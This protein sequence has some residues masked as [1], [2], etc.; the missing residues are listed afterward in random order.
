MSN[1]NRDLVA[2]VLA[3]ELAEDS[4]EFREAVLADPMLQIE[5]DE[6]RA[7]TAMM[8]G[9]AAAEREARTMPMLE[10][11][12]KPA[13]SGPKFGG[14]FAGVAAAAALLIA[15]FAMQGLFGG[16]DP[17]ANTGN[18]QTLS[19]GDLD[20]TQVSPMGPDASYGTFTATGAIPSIASIEL[21]I[22]EDSEDADEPIILP[23]PITAEE[24]TPEGFAWSPSPEILGGL[25]ARIRWQIR[26]IGFGGNSIG[27]S[28]MF[29]ASR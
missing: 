5:L 4:P 3:G 20:F 19:A 22:W 2:D 16:N 11:V 8:D 27:D 9:E 28:T 17:T 6:M 25:P 13:S 18:L 12:E 10:L 15:I 7:L 26:L 1:Q 23:H 29:F 24:L 21:W 14:R